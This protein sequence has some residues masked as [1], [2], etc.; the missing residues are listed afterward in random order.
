MIYD[1]HCAFKF[2]LYPNDEQRRQMDMT[3]RACA[4]VWNLG[5]EL[6]EAHYELHRDDPRKD[7]DV[8]L[9][10]GEFAKVD[11]T[12]AHEVLHVEGR[13]D[14]LIKSVVQALPTRDSNNTGL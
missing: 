7:V 6:S 2:K 12:H 1:G 4:K 8:R 13:K 11:M 3:M 5:L 10:H 14:V 9:G